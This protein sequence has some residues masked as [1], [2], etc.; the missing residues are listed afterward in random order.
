MKFIGMDETVEYGR[1]LFVKISDRNTTSYSIWFA[2][3]SAVMCKTW[4]HKI[5]HLKCISKQFAV[6]QLL[7]FPVWKVNKFVSFMSTLKVIYLFFFFIPKGRISKQISFFLVTYKVYIKTVNSLL[8]LSMVNFIITVNYYIYYITTFTTITTY[9]HAG[10]V[11][12]FKTVN[13]SVW[14][15]VTFP[16]HYYCTCSRRNK[17]YCTH[18]IA[19]IT[20]GACRSRAK[21]LFGRFLGAIFILSLC[22][23]YFLK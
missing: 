4:N 10:L 17:P 16:E 23:F 21:Y 7:G 15:L 22:S 14:Y 8:S 11:A 5:L 3:F 12:A 18:G 13:K 20:T 9:M 2:P 1:L 19:K 6:F